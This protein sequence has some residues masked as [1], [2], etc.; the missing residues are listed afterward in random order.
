MK[1]YYVKDT[2]IS[3][4]GV[5]CEAVS[6]WPPHTHH[7]D[8]CLGDDADNMCTGALRWLLIGGQCAAGFY[9]GTTGTQESC[10]KV[11]VLVKIEAAPACDAHTHTHTH[12][13]ECSMSY[14]AE[15]FVVY[16]P[17]R[18]EVW[19]LRGTRYGHD[20]CADIVRALASSALQIP[21]L[22]QELRNA[23]M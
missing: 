23:Q 18:R 1:G 8:L 17:T 4:G 5:T 3:N 7:H 9:F 20:L 11:S 13:R 21:S 12:M 22:P 6:E 19:L 14:Q 2:A 16:I 15:V 10:D